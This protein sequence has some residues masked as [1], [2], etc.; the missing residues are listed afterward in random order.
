MPVVPEVDGV[1]AARLN[2]VFQDDTRRRS[3]RRLARVVATG[4]RRVILQRSEGSHLKR[5]HRDQWMVM[6]KVRVEY[7]RPPAETSP[8]PVQPFM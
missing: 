5:L 7:W 3:S 2:L 6:A 8:K 4:I 1:L